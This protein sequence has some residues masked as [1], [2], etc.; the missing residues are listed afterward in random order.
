M[1][2]LDDE[3]YKGVCS[4]SSSILKNNFFYSNDCLSRFI[5]IFSDFVSDEYNIFYETACEEFKRNLSIDIEL[6]KD[7]T[8]YFLSMI[9]SK[10]LV[11]DFYFNDLELEAF[12][13]LLPELIGAKQ[14]AN[15]INKRAH[16]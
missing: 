11:E 1:F 10:I 4:I 6:R 16:Y 2:L 3:I 13:N 14:D 8:A 9:L 7:F 5:I 12:D 15:K